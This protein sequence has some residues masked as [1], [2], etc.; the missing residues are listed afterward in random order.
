MNIAVYTLRGVSE[1][2]VTM[3][4]LILLLLLAFVLYTKNKK[5]VIMQRMII[6]EPMNS[7]F[8]LTISQI[9]LGI[10]AGAAA[11]L[12]LSYMGIIF[13][14]EDIISILFTI[15]IVLMLFRS[16]F[17]CFSYSAGILCMLSV[18][19]QLYE[20]ISNV[21]LPQLDFFKVDVVMIMSLV[22]ILHIVEGIL[23]M[24]DG[25]KGSIPVFTNRNNKIIGGFALKR[26][27]A[28]PVALLFIVGS[29]SISNGVN[30][31][32]PDFWPLIKSNYTRLLS[33]MAIG[34]LPFY[35]MIGYSSITFTKT[36]R[37]KAFASGVLI[38]IYGAVLL[39]FAQIAKF[40]LITQFIVA[41]FAPVA[42]EFMLRIQVY[43]EMKQ[44]PKYVSTEDG[45]MV[46]EVAPS[47]P[48]FEMGIKSGD[49][50]VEVN[51]RKIFSEQ[52][53][54]DALNEMSNFIWLKVKTV[55]GKLMKVDYNKMNSSKKL[56]IIFVPKTIPK[57]GKTFKIGKNNFDE[58]L[59]KKLKK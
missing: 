32:T 59:K 18:V 48:A 12:I 29:S 36:K 52:D 8:E 21:S 3:P 55:Q 6:G 41:I 38:S 34:I 45:L 16:R 26:Y 1:A 49:L 10:L 47:S 17:I 23:V 24:I 19:L 27:W 28:M 35:G 56:G 37:E 46:L 39:V 51:D 44:K 22:A 4:Y 5:T 42:H 54:I 2:I 57:N 13:K 50:L 25:D 14:N 40:N 30:I 9:V 43:F 31:A 11:S 15:S 53:M 33:T 7:S 20:R 58:I